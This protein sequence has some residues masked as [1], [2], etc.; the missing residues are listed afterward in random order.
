M[1]LSKRVFRWEGDKTD[2]M[3]VGDVL[4][5][6]FCR[7]PLYLQ[8]SFCKS[9]LMPTMLSQFVNRTDFVTFISY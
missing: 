2:T 8:I 5:K 7:I 4:P 6:E 9:C 3:D 1:A